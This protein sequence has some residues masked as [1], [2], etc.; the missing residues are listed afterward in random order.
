M[1]K[2]ST[3]GFTIIEVLIASLVFTTLLLLC[4]EGITRIAKV[5]IKSSSTTRA[6]EFANAFI[7][8]IAQQVKYGATIQ[9]TAGTNPIYFCVADSAYKITINKKE[10]EAPTGINPI[11]KISYPGCANGYATAD[12][13]SGQNLAPVDVRILKFS[14]TSSGG[15]NPIWT[16]NMRV[17]IGDK[18]LLVD[19]NLPPKDLND[20]S[21]NLSTA[22]CKGRAGGEFCA[23]IETTTSASRR[24]R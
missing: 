5:Y 22:K 19:N 1:K 20:A 21:A 8:D 17:A 2:L 16:I 9:P 24:M 11:I 15:T 4:M 12:Y 7:G 23:V 18:D 10:T 14:V 13:S 3:K 6:S